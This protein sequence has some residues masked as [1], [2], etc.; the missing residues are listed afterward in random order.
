MYFVE[1]KEINYDYEKLLN[2]PPLNLPASIEMKCT[3][4]P[5]YDDDMAIDD[6]SPSGNLF[7]FSY[8]L[9]INP[10]FTFNS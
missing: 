4:K 1:Q 7:V 5:T 8:F 6:V 9:S 3:P 2:L 10:S